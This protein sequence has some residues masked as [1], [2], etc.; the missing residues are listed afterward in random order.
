MLAVL[1]AL[2]SALC[3]AFAS[4]LQ[5]LT[6]AQ[7][8]SQL[9]L[10]PRL[11][12][13]LVRRPLWLVGIAGDVAGFLLEFV[14]LSLGALAVV[15]PVMVSG[16][17]FALPLAALV[18][19]KRMG[20]AEWR[21][22]IEV[23][24]GLSV[25]LVVAAPEGGSAT[26]SAAAWVIVAVTTVVPAGVLVAVAGPQGP[27]RAT[28]LALATGLVFGLTAALTKAAGHRLDAGMETFLI[29]WETYALLVVGLTSMLLTQSAFQ[30]GPLASSLPVLGVMEPLVGITIGTLAFDEALNLEGVAPVVEVLS[31]ALMLVGAWRLARSQ[32]IAGIGEEAPR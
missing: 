26:M 19:H 17:L 13:E 31:L 32:L 23:V 21:G 12:L 29:S 18:E 1:A 22:G 10:R 14:A 2:V 4:V 30:A 6:A 16:L 28:V 20:G 8:P 9:S 7:V 15:Q 25:F 24:V 11:L 27:R 5:R 3:Y